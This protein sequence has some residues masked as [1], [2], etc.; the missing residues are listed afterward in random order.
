MRC[1][2]ALATL[3]ETD[4]KDIVPL[5]G[6]DAA[7]LK[8]GGALQVLTT[9]HL[10]AVTN[11]PVLMSKITTIHALGDIWGMGADPQAA[12][13]SLTLPRM[14]AS[15]QQRTVTEITQTI[16]ANLGSAALVGGHT[17]DG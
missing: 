14:S 3:P 17:H 15:L 16:V 7:L 1:K 13:L 8:T 6:D 11:D 9:D 5:A 4:R 10:S 12:V 2:S